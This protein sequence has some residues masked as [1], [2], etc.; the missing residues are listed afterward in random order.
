MNV[1]A[2]NI[3]T[4][5]ILITT[6]HCLKRFV[7]ITHQVLLGQSHLNSE[8]W[9]VNS[10]V[11]N[12]SFVQT[13]PKY[14]GWTAYYDVGLVHTAGEIEFTKST[15]PLL[16]PEKP[17]SN[18]EGTTVTIAG[19]GIEKPA[20]YNRDFKLKKIQL[21]VFSTEYCNGKY[22]VT[23]GDDGPKHEKFLPDLFN[24]SV[25]CAGLTVC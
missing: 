9:D 5:N 12:I 4:K 22:N 21:T 15:K 23:G 3:L 20:A 24:N 17:L 6:A 18:I 7:R 8:F 19:W 14:D 25:S 13:H 16:L 1:C 11:L 10:Q 2:A